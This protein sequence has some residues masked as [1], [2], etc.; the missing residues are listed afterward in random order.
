MVRNLRVTELRAFTQ[1]G[2]FVPVSVKTF[3]KHFLVH[4]FV[5]LNLIITYHKFYL[6]SFV[7]ARR[8]H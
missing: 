2:L 3:R 5:S 7:A 1:R 8:V 4:I 6:S